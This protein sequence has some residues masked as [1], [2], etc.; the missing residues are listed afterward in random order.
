MASDPKANRMR[1]NN[2]YREEEELLLL[3][4]I[5][6]FKTKSLPKRRKVCSKCTPCFQCNKITNFVCIH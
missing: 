5:S 2:N 4:E 6:K 1:S 3:E